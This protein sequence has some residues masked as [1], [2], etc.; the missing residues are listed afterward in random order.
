M[1]TILQKPGRVKR[2]WWIIDAEKKVLGR[3]AVKVAEKI[4]G[5]GKIDYTPHVDG[6]DFVIVINA[7][8]VKITGSKMAEKVYYTYSGYLGHQKKITLQELMKKK[9]ELVIEHAVKGMINRNKL[10]AKML[11]RLKIFAGPEHRHQAQNPEV[12][13]L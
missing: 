6:G 2:K 8:K 10:K 9:P 13:D 3:L 1:K 12:L 5:R 7:E 11:K 4:S